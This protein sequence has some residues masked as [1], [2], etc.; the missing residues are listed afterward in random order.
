MVTTVKDVKTMNKYQKAIKTLKEEKELKFLIYK[1]QEFD[2]EAPTM[3]DFYHHEMF[4]LDELVEKATP[5]KPID[6]TKYGKYS[7]GFF[8][9]HNETLRDLRCPN[10]KKKV[11][12]V[13]K[14]KYCA[15]CGQ[16]L[17]WG[18]E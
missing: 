12:L 2:D 6:C 11:R 17:D 7:K 4:I 18:D 1:G 10:C 9:G 3:F 15:K 5:K 14:Y 16:A 13:H 8:E